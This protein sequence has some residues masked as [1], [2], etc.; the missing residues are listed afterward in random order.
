MIYKSGASVLLL[1][2]FLLSPLSPYVLRLLLDVIFRL[3][4]Q[5]LCLLSPFILIPISS[6]YVCNCT[7]PFPSY[8]THVA[9]DLL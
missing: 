2:F 4:A 3:M 9:K 5:L 7:D 8:S 1:L 6:Y